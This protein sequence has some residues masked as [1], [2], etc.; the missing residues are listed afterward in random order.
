MVFFAH[1]NPVAWDPAEDGAAPATADPAQLLPPS[2]TDDV[3]LHRDLVRLLVEGAFGTASSRPRELL[4]NADELAARFRALKPP[5]FDAS[6]DRRGGRGEYVVVLRPQF[7]GGDAVLD[8]A[9]LEIWTRDGSA[10]MSAWKQIH[11]L[12]IEHGRRAAH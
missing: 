7:S 12:V 6:G 2:G 1:Q 9:S 8:S 3:L 4:S 10:T 5:F 11:K